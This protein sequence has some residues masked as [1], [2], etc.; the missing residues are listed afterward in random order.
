MAEESLMS[1]PLGRAHP[2]FHTFNT[3]TTSSRATGNNLECRVCEEGF[4]V[5]GDK[6]PR[7]LYCGHTLCHACLLRLPVTATGESAATAEFAGRGAAA[8]SSN[9]AGVICCPFDRQP[10]PIGRNGVWAL[11]KN[12]ALLE[13]LERGSNTAG[14]GQGPGDRP[15]LSPDL[16]TQHQQFGS[17]CGTVACDEDES[18]AAMLYCTVCASHLCHACSERSHATKTLHTHRRIPIADKPREKPRC[19]SHPSHTVE[20]VCLEPACNN[21]SPLM[22][23][24]CKDYKHTKHKHALLE[25]EAE[26]VR[27]ELSVATHNIKR[28]ALQLTHT[29]RKLEQTARQLEDLPSESAGELN[30]SELVPG[31]ARVSSASLMPG[32]VAVTITSNTGR[33]GSPNNVTSSNLL[34][35]GTLLQSNSINSSSNNASVIINSS[36]T[37][38]ANLLIPSTNSVISQQQ[39]QQM[40]HTTASQS[41]HL[42]SSPSGS[43]SSHGSNPQSYGSN[44]QTHVLTSHSSNT[45]GYGSSLVSH[46]GHDQHAIHVSSSTNNSN[47]H[48]TVA[49]TVVRDHFSSLREQLQQQESTAINALETHVRERLCSIRQQQEDLAALVSQMVGLVLESERCLQQD[50][51][52]V[53]VAGHSLTSKL[54]LLQQQQ[55]QLDAIDL[56]L[57]TVQDN[58]PITFTKDNR[59]HIGAVLEMRVVTLGLDGAGKTSILFRLQENLCPPTIPTIGFNVE[60]LHYKNFKFTIWDVGGQPKLRPLW[61][62]YYFNTQAIIFVV[63]ASDAARLEEAMAELTKLMMEHELR[64][65]PLLIYANKQS[66]AGA[67]SSSDVSLALGAGKLCSGR[68]WHVVACDAK[69]GDGLTDGLDWLTRQLGPLNS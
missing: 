41:S 67:L 57:S 53:L 22:C 4:N 52:R 60:T 68:A 37:A 58:I 29:L 3:G 24:I 23:F 12:F 26:N 66:V 8:G 45:L 48:L 27:Q 54:Q 50:D 65:A 34:R 63:D 49:R 15:L 28:T 10:T 30:S 31:S 13:V 56:E 7:L 59:I 19:P 39:Q 38:A 16:L 11:K 18:H 55:P 32:S 51:G 20:F 21:S 5:T 40:L 61:R 62:H 47:N 69:T 36:P 2:S 17:V 14:V 64:D 35:T 6:V 25:S 42:S 44:T 9:C 1:S 33:S 43:L 46:S